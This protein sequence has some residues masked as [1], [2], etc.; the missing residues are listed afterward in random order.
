VLAVAGVVGSPA[1][2]IGRSTKAP[3]S[4]TV[5]MLRSR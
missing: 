5:E 4:L 1:R 3:C 2:T